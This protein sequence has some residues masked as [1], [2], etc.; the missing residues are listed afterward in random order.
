[1]GRKVEGRRF[2]YPLRQMNSFTQAVDSSLWS[3]RA[4]DDAEYDAAVA[5]PFIPPAVTLPVGP[6]SSP[7]TLIVLAGTAPAALAR[8]YFA[9]A[10]PAAP[11]ETDVAMGAVGHL[12]LALYARGTGGTVLVVPQGAVID[13]H[14][15]AWARCVL[16]ALRPRRVVVL[17]ALPAFRVGAQSS[18]S[19]DDDEWRRMG[20][21]VEDGS[22]GAAPLPGLRVLG[23]PAHGLMFPVLEPPVML[24]GVAAATLCEAEFRQGIEACAYIA[25]IDAAVVEVDGECLALFNQVLDAELRTGAP[26]PEELLARTKRHAT[27]VKQASMASNVNSLYTRLSNKTSKQDQIFASKSIL[28]RLPRLTA[29]SVGTHESSRRPTH[30]CSKTVVSV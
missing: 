14:A 26:T 9:A 21:E 13:A 30:S 12:P 6:T 28:P 5:T 10:T 1:V 19:D 27:Q 20:R 25:R 17:A 4:F 15:A 29:A 16:D 24:E 22:R 3:S 7:E 11:G 23:T 8:S 2:S 18:N